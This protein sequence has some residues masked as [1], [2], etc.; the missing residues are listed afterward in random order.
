MMK[1]TIIL[2]IF[3]NQNKTLLKYK[4][5]QYITLKTISQ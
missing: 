3:V 4:E 2:I 1:S 5:T